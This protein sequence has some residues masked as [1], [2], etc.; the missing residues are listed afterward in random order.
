M[1]FRRE[2]KLFLVREALKNGANLLP[3]ISEERLLSVMD[4]KLASIAHDYPE[5]RAFLARMA[6][7]WK[8]KLPS[9]S[10]NCRNKAISNFFVNGLITGNE[11]RNAFA[12]KNGFKPPF[13]FVISPSMACNLRCYGCYAGEYAKDSG[14]PYSVLSRLLN[15]AKDMG[16]YFITISGGEPFVRKDLLDLFREFDDMYF[17]VYTNGTLIDDQMAKKL[18]KL[19]NVVPCIS[20]EGF[21]RETEERRGKGTYGRVMTAMDSLRQEGVLFGFSATATRSNNEFILSDQFIDFYVQKGCFI[22]WYFNYMPIGRCPE[23]ELMPTPEQRNWRRERLNSIRDAQPI[24]MSDF[25]NDGPLTGGC[26]AGGRSYFHIN[27]H[28]DVEPCV[29]VHFAA[30][31]IKDKSLYEVLNSKLFWAIRKRQPYNNNLLR[32]C[33]IIDNPNVLREVIAEGGAHPTHPGAETIINELAGALDKYAEE[34]GKLV[35]SAWRERCTAIAQV[36]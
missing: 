35:D 2:L 33:M 22:G 14:L 12:Q 29:F 17:Q 23:L 31:N 21:E 25:W 16:I 24:L 3:L 4:E 27:S 19:G 10:K 11:K 8:R 6:L 32:P 30:D 9:M 15:E 28:G 1:Q 36:V 20:V 34:Y 5:G 7:Q 13:F 18:A 26:I